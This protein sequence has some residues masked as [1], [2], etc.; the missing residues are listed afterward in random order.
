MIV[1]AQINNYKIV[2]Q[3]GSGAF[4]LVYLCQ[5]LNDASKQYACKAILKQQS[6]TS[7]MNDPNIKKSNILQTQ[8]YHYFKSLSY[9]IFLP[10]LNLNSL[11]NMPLDQLQS[12]NAYYREIILHLKSNHL[13]NVVKINEILESSI[14]VFIF[15]EYYPMD[16]FTSIVDNQHFINNPL[17]I[18]KCFIQLAGLIKNLADIGIYHCD[19][20]PEN[21]LLDSFDNI[22]LCDF[23]LAT[24]KIFL[25]LD[26]CVGSSYY[27]APERVSGTSDIVKEHI[28]N[29]KVNDRLKLMMS[30]S[31]GEQYPTIAGD[32]W[33]LTIILMNLL[34]TRNPWL[35]AIPSDNTFSHFIK[36]KRVLSKIL[37]LSDDMLELL[38]G[39]ENMGEAYIAKNKSYNQLKDFDSDPL[40]GVKLHGIMS[41]NPWERGDSEVLTYFIER[42]AKSEQF[43]RDSVDTTTNKTIKGGRLGLVRPLENFEIEEILH[44]RQQPQIFPQINKETSFELLMNH[45]SINNNFEN[46]NIKNN[47]MLPNQFM[48]TV[49]NSRENTMRTLSSTGSTIPNVNNLFDFQNTNYLNFNEESINKNNDQSSFFELSLENEAF[50]KNNSNQNGNLNLNIK[51]FLNK[52][53]SYSNALEGNDIDMD[54]KDS[55][56]SQYNYPNYQ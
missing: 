50:E 9:K 37:D 56:F 30:F 20:K 26:T 43:S 1:N 47:N 39:T 2:K 17:L 53:H 27:M 3:I 5:D 46:R 11:M 25:N 23:G 28:S 49:V 40:S 35:K 42:V 19:I 36:N 34:T 45:F 16:L 7:N 6:N 51:S 10:S 24:D 21:I 48:N 33:S 8:L 13:P 54:M 52:M 15:M 29:T 4:G 55:I 22:Q 44:K 18:K 32:I 31:N 14:A 12:E 41:L 38:I